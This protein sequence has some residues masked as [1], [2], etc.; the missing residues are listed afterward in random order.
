MFRRLY[1]E[2]CGEEIAMEEAREMASRSLM[3][4]ELL[5]SPLPGEAGATIQQPLDDD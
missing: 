2:A 4:Y 3:L 1:K 5:Y